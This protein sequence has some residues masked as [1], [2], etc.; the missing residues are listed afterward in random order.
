M[1]LY[2]SNPDMS[3]NNLTGNKSKSGGG[4]Y[5]WEKSNPDL[6]NNIIIDNEP[7][8]IIEYIEPK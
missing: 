3:D 2:E 8:N 7:D 5:M 4:I 1:F 6:T